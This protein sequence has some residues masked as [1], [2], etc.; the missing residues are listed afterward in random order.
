MRKIPDYTARPY[1]SDG[2]VSRLVVK[3][4]RLTYSSQSGVEL[5]CPGFSYY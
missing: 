4:P 5:A 3:L 1:T 2:Q